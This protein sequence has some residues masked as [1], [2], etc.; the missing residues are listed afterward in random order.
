VSFIQA[1]YIP[2]SPLPTDAY[3]YKELLMDHDFV[4]IAP[5][6]YH[7]LKE[8]GRLEATPL[9]FQE[10]I[11]TEFKKAYYQN[12]FIKHQ[13]EKIC[14]KFEEEAIEVIPIKGPFFAERY[15]G[16]IGA[17][18]TSDIDLL[19]K[20]SD[21]EHAKEIVRMLGFSTEEVFIPG[22]F[23]CSFSKELPGSQ[24]PLTV[25]LHWHILIEKTTC[26]DISEL[27][28]EAVL[29]SSYRYVKELSPYHTF[30][31]M[32]IH[33][34]RNNLSSYKH[35]M[36]IIQL[37][38]TFRDGLNFDRFKVDIDSHCTSKRIIRTLSIVYQDFPHLLEI[39]QCPLIRS[40]SK[41]RKNVIKNRNN[42]GFW[43]CIDFVD[44][45]F[46]S[47]DTLRHSVMY[48]KYLYKVKKLV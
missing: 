46:F 45:K 32:C 29:V 17:R 34:W 25:E 3:V 7:L 19:I 43:K 37:M 8:Q 24:I 30:Y 28:N 14:K 9:F 22:H 39:K 12:L 41:L 40:N 35:F 10:H 20:L 33:G 38:H 2:S 42:K 36:D 23:H 4:S 31:L 16:H 48:L 44:H 27:W 1:L 15:F 26:F 21:L 5:Q 6:V 18:P 13:T 11:K 47:Y